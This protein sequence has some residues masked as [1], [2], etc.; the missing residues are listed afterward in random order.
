MPVW[1]SAS[2][3]NEASP[4]INRLMITQDTGGAIRG[5]V[6]GD[7]FWGYGERAEQMAGGMKSKGRYWFL[8]PKTL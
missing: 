1:L 5:P 6:R 7:F 8:L 4:N 2:A 3:P